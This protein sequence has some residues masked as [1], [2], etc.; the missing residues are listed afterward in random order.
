MIP[1]LEFED[2]ML[3][4]FLLVEQLEYQQHKPEQQI[5][6]RNFGEH[7]EEQMSEKQNMMS[8]SWKSWRWLWDFRGG[9]WFT[10][11]NLEELWKGVLTLIADSFDNREIFF[12]IIFSTVV[13]IFFF[14]FDG[15]SLLRISTSEFTLGKGW[16]VDGADLSGPTCILCCF[17]CFRSCF[18]LKFVKLHVSISAA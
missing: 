1:L 5:S 13:W 2:P 16:G 8:T 10:I 11:S 9:S 18:W 12:S 15:I 7:E 6:K 17:S 3:G 4:Q 14:C